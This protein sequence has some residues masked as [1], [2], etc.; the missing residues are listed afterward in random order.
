MS[1]DDLKK[2][3]AQISD[4][5]HG[6]RVYDVEY[7]CQFFWSFS[8]LCEGTM[9]LHTRGYLPE[10]R[11]LTGSRITS[12]PIATRRGTVQTCKLSSFYMLMSL[13]VG[14]ALFT[15][16]HI[17][18]E[19]SHLSTKV[20]KHLKVCSVATR[21]DWALQIVQDDYL[22][23]KFKDNAHGRVPHHQ[24]AH[25]F[26]GIT[27]SPCYAVHFFDVCLTKVCSVA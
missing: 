23:Y 16:G 11:A 6:L 10:G 14:G 17:V 8:K 2:V 21:Y 24:H 12:R 25:P 1:E 13:L 20:H 3:L 22:Y 19:E 5:A 26:L 7:A 27:Y 15:A 18:Y 9:A 4:P